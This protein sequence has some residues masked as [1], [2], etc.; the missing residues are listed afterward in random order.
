MHTA[1][2]IARPDRN[3]RM[4]GHD[5]A[6]THQHRAAASTRALA[7][8]CPRHSHCHL[9]APAGSAAAGTARS[10]INTRSR[11]VPCSGVG[12]ARGQ[13]PHGATDHSLARDG[14]QRSASATSPRATE[15]PRSLRWFWPPTAAASLPPALTRPCGHRLPQPRTVPSC[16]HPR[17]PAPRAGGSVPPPPRPSRTF[18]AH[19]CQHRDPS[20]PRGAAPA[21]SLPGRSPALPHR[22]A[23]VLQ[24]RAVRRVRP[25]TAVEMGSPVPPCPG[26]VLPRGGRSMSPHMLA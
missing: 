22:P 8:V 25:H 16:H 23:L 7:S 17:P 6:P 9:P 19:R 12:H 15:A 2:F 14:T 18:S 24:G 13:Q 3:G 20:S 5:T 26:R 11:R 21:R 10:Y 4:G 1:R